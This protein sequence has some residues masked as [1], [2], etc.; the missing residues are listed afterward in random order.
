LDKLVFTSKNNG[1]PGVIGRVVDRAA[2]KIAEQRCN[3]ELDMV[4]G[5]GICMGAEGRRERTEE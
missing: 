4:T 5:L 3:G 2:P 1:R